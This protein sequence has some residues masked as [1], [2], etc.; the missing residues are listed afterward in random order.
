MQERLVQRKVMGGLTREEAEA[1][2]RKS[3]RRNIRRLMNSHCQADEVLI[4]EED[5]S[6]IRE[7][8]GELT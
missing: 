1:F 7:E 5:G 2:Y 4:M 3:D 8:K 6:Y